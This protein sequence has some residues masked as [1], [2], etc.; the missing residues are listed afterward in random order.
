MYKTPALGNLL[1]GRHHK[2]IKKN[3]NTCREVIGA[4]NTTVPGHP[5]VPQHRLTTASSGAFPPVWT[6]A[7]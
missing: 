6:W 4:G 3:D 2:H 1:E 7:K 5:T